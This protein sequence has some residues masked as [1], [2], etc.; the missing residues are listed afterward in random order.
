MKFWTFAACMVT[1]L[2]IGV[3]DF[4][5]RGAN[6]VARLSTEIILFIDIGML[7]RGLL[8]YFVSCHQEVLPS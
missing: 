1:P 4:V 7:T 3:N 8:F 5:A 6:L 2:I